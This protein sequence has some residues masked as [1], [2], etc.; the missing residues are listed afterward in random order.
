MPSLARWDSTKKKLADV[1]DLWECL[2]QYYGVEIHCQMAYGPTPWPLGCQLLYT[3]YHF[4]AGEVE[5]AFTRE[6][7]FNDLTQS[8]G[9]EELYHDLLMIDGY[10]DVSMGLWA[11]DCPARQLHRPG[12]EIFNFGKMLSWW[13][14]RGR[15][16]AQ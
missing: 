10:L 4:P 6:R 3:V 1:A 11:K 7:L 9:A 2:Q 14:D 16:D 13:R 15:H 12:E 5:I 8:V